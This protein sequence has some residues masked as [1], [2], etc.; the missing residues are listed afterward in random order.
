MSMQNKLLAGPAQKS[1]IDLAINP[2]A[3]HFGGRAGPKLMIPAVKRTSVRARPKKSPPC[4]RTRAICLIGASGALGRT[5]A[6][7]ISIAAVIVAFEAA[8]GDTCQLAAPS[9][10]GRLAPRLASKTRKPT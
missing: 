2:P 9:P 5:R 10:A 6:D 3:T 7:S 8:P 1:P 4:S